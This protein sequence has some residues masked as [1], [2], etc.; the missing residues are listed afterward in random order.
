MCKS[1][2]SAL[3]DHAVIAELRSSVGTGADDLFRSFFREGEER[4]AVLRTLTVDR[5]DSIRF[6]LH[7]L[8]G[9]A[10]MFGLAH[11]SALLRAL[12]GR[13][14]S[15]SPEAYR[16]ALDEIAATL[17]ASRQALIEPV[18]RSD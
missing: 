3:V 6:Q 2:S 1:F 14:E 8:H 5:T 7:S 16:L 13:S 9:A 10:G 12:Y 15:L 4:L 18:S 11:L 17:A